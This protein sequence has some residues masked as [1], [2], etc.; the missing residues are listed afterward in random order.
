M[1]LNETSFGK[2]LSFEYIGTMYKNF[3][4]LPKFLQNK[5]NFT[6]LEEAKRHE[7]GL[8]YFIV[9]L[10]DLII[11]KLEIQRSTLRKM[12]YV[13]PEVTLNIDDEKHI[14]SFWDVFYK[15]ISSYNTHDVFENE[16][17]DFS[18]NRIEQNMF[19]FSDINIS[20]ILKT[21]CM[22]F[23]DIDIL[24]QYRLS[25]KLKSDPRLKEYIQAKNIFEE[26]DD[27]SNST[28]LKITCLKH[29]DIIKR[30]KH[31]FNRYIISDFARK[32]SSFSLL[33]SRL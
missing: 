21:Q 22:C 25:S 7:Y 3:I 33:L 5:L 24:L 16:E 14:V 13:F 19:D 31:G 1:I 28:L 9:R 17:V 20:N 27:C 30:V 12:L 23:L 6:Y 10:E 32:S 15:L 8:I 18:Q 29:L 11:Q 26:C 4:L 2:H